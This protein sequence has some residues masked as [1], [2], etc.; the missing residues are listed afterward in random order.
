MTKMA[1]K[2]IYG[3]NYL[4]IFFSGA[5]RQWHWDLLCSIEDVV[6]TRFAQMM[7][8]GWPWPTNGKVKFDS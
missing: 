2:L 1:T 6:L 8:L 4:N 3:K 7:N 5:K